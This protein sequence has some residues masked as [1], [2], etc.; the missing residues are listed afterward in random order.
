MDW[1]N[2]KEYLDYSFFGISLLQILVA[3]IAFI[4]LFALRK[5]FS[6][7]ISGILLSLTRKSRTELDDK[8]IGAIR[9]PLEYLV[10]IIGLYIAVMILRLPTKPANVLFF[11]MSLIK[12]MVI[13]D[14][15]WLL[16]QTVD[17][18]AEHF[19]SLTKGTETKMDDQIVPLLRTA[20]KTLIGIL[21]F[22]VIVQNM[23]YSVTGLMAGLGIGG[24]A[25]ALAA[26]DT[27][28]NL[29]GSL[30]IFT[31]RPFQVGDYIKIGNIGGTVEE[32][33]I[34]ITRLRTSEKTLISIPNKEIASKAIDNMSLRLKRRYNATIGLSYDI[35]AEK[36]QQAIDATKSIVRKQ[37]GVD[38][39]ESIVVSFT[40][41]GESSLNVLVRFYT[42]TSDYDE[43]LRVQQ[44]VNLEIMRRLEELDVEITYPCLSVYMKNTS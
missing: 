17:A 34:R 40:D 2:I 12:A 43:F 38:P 27:L 29:F 44:E 37:D 5:P 28:S 4:G 35:T 9:K 14:I 7:L 32:V 13:L 8:V 10:I 3:F 6:M 31:D 18:F 42:P 30:T 22:V 26:Q 24:L 33:G 15:T 11:A 25:L 36:L 21:G 39:D 20:T 41:F 16:L 23:G 1:S 19:A